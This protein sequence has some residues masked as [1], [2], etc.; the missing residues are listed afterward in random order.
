[1]NDPDLYVGITSLNSVLFLPHC[2]DSLRRT[3]GSARLHICVLDN[4]SSDASATIA[5]DHGVELLV[6]LCTQPEAP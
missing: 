4:D 6:G 2:L 3:T 5:L 1:M